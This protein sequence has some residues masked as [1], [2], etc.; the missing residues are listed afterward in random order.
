MAGMGWKKGGLNA[1]NR[2]MKMQSRC[3]MWRLLAQ[4]W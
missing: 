3:W 2:G 1:C 4:C